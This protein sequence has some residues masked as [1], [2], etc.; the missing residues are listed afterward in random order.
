MAVEII[1][2][3]APMG[4]PLTTSARRMVPSGTKSRQSARPI[5]SGCRR[6]R[7]QASKATKL[8]ALATSVAMAEPAMPMRGSGPRPK[9]S[10]GFSAVSNTTTSSKKRNGVRVSP[11]PRSTAEMKANKYSSGIA[12]NSVRR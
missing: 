3:C 6:Q 5:Q 2:I 12:R 7:S 10:S 8:I 9:M 4:R 1:T 11:A